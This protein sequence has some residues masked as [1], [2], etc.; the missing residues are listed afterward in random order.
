[1]GGVLF[2]IFVPF[3]KWDYGEATKTRKKRRKKGR[4]TERQKDRQSDRQ[5]KIDSEENVS[6]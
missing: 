5:K 6:L 1:M 2:R 3:E 4:Q